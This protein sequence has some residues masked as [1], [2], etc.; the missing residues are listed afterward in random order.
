VR[1]GRAYGPVVARGRYTAARG[2]QTTV[3]VALG[4]A[5]RGAKV[6]VH[7]VEQGVSKKGP[8]YSQRLLLVR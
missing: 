5:R 2:K 8:R 4:S 1:L 6:F 3:R 7:T